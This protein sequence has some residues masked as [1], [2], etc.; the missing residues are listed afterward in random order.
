MTNI[1]ALLGG[2]GLNENQIEEVEW[3]AA[4][5]AQATAAAAVEGRYK[6]HGKS[7]LAVAEFS[8]LADIVSDFALNKFRL[9]FTVEYTIALS[10][11]FA[12]YDR[13]YKD[14]K[15]TNERLSESQRNALRALVDNFSM[16]D[17]HQIKLFESKSDH[18]LA[19]AVDWLKYTALKEGILSE[20]AAD[21]AHF[22]LTSANPEIAAFGLMNDAIL[23]NLLLPKVINLIE[24]LY[25]WAEKHD[26]VVP[27]LTHLQP[28]E[29]TFFLR[30]ITGFANSLRKNLMKLVEVPK[31]GSFEIGYP[32]PIRFP[33]G[34]SGAVGNY[35]NHY[36]AYPDINWRCFA[37]D[38]ITGL[39]LKFELITDQT[40]DFTDYLHYFTA[41]AGIANDVWKLGNDLSHLTELQWL[42]K[43]KKKGAKASSVL[44]GKTGNAWR[45]EGARFYLDKGINTL[46]HS[47]IQLRRY[48]HEGNME[49][50]VNMRE[51]GTNMMYLLIGIDR[52]RQE[53]M[54]WIPWDSRIDSYI[55]N[56]AALVGSSA[57]TI[58]KREGIAGDPY[59]V[60]QEVS[61]DGDEPVTR[62]KYCENLDAAFSDGRLPA[63]CRAVG[64][65]IKGLLNHPE[66]NMGIAKILSDE[67]KEAIF[68]TFADLKNAYN[69]HIIIK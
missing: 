12:N 46:L 27:A 52:T 33:A 22:G 63:E 17:Y 19:A 16:R 45:A 56:N 25:T 57:Q 69:L 44:I 10:D 42:K 36:A 18:D 66:T 55:E 21:A 50:S 7:P 49:R 31:D 20:K 67:V 59:R 38:F 47:A 54:S 48:P 24:G 23:R 43:E 29:P 39:G 11:L 26:R 37:K 51:L 13:K 14:K 40:I 58:L 65:E 5:A 15:M 3:S 41:V 9:K 6:E 8:T 30:K 1:E 35:T 68:S 64:E 34:L 53:F 2:L 62:E 28:A 60:I 32:K 61:F 4:Q